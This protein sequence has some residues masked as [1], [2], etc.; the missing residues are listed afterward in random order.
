MVTERV[1]GMRYALQR[2]RSQLGHEAAF[3]KRDYSRSAMTLNI[4]F[5]LEG[6]VRVPSGLATK[7]C[8]PQSATR[9][10]TVTLSLGQY[11][12][13]P[14]ILTLGSISKYTL[15]GMQNVAIAAGRRARSALHVLR[16]F[17]YHDSLSR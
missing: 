7:V 3:W 15:S 5:S 1:E 8:M 17:D 13:P 2:R 12:T 14:N 4:I 11:S 6:V 10:H 9:P 16:L